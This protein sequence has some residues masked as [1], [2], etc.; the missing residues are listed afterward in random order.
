MKKFIKELIEGV[1]WFAFGAVLGLLFIEAMRLML[2][3]L[4]RTHCR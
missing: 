2:A 3:V 4:Q 1:C